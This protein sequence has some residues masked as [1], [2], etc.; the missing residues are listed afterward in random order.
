M[1]NYQKTL[2]ANL[3]ALCSPEQEAFYYADQNWLDAKFRIFLY[4]LASYTEFLQPS[5]LEC[6]GH[7]FRINDA[8]EPLELVSI[9]P[10]KFFNLD[11]NPFVMG[12]DLSRIEAVFEKLDGSLISTVKVSDDFFL[13]S[14]GSFTSTQAQDATVLICSPG[15][16][17]FYRACKSLVASGYTV[18]S[19]FCAPHNQIVLGYETPMLKVLNVRSLQDGSYLP[20]NEVIS[21]FGKDAVAE[22]YPLPE[23]PE[24][25]IESVKRMTGIEGYVVHHSDS[26]FKLKTDEY[27][28][29]HGLVS[30]LNSPRRLYELI[31][32]ETIDD[33]IPIIKDNAYLMALLNAETIRIRHIYVSTEALVTEFFNKHKHLTRKDFAILGQSEV[34][35]QAFSLAMN[36]YVG[37]PLDMKEFM[38]RKYDMFKLKEEPE[39]SYLQEE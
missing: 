18:N 29:L 16:D 23:D 27:K 5:A 32:N 19:E 25:W 31:I 36:L 20:W 38:L 12:L 37:K 8:G 26:W 10:Q 21:L 14:K 34:P 15:Y 22:S 7:V 33:V 28:S 30:N 1:N 24:Q 6:R 2:Y 3:M 4:R 9:A 35:A 17:E 13:K 39:E 11:E